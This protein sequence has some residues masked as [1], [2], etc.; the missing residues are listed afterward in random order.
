M[1][2]MVVLAK[3]SYDFTDPNTQNRIRGQNLYCVDPSFREDDGRKYGHF[4]LKLPCTLE[5]LAGVSECPGSYE[6]ELR[7]ISSSGGKAKTVIVGAKFIKKL[8][9]S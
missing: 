2:V 3:D 1:S 8:S 5:V 7:Q 4:P 9:L 6:L